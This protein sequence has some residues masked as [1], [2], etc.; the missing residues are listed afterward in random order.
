MSLNLTSLSVRITGSAGDDITAIEIDGV[1]VPI[2]VDRTWQLTVVVPPQRRVVA[3][4]A[5][6]PDR[7][8]TRAVTLERVAPGSVPA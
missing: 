3:I 8:E 1:A 2:A 7:V 6:G 4:T 5:S